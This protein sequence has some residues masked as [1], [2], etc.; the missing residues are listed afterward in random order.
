MP[1]PYSVV[2]LARP[3]AV[4]RDPGGSLSDRDVLGRYVVPLAMADRL[5]PTRV[6]QLARGHA[7]VRHA[8]AA[9][10]GHGV[11]RV[12]SGT[13]PVAY[14]LVVDLQMQARRT[15]CPRCGDP[16]S[17]LEGLREHAGAVEVVLFVCHQCAFRS[18]QP[19]FS[20][21]AVA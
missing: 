7:T 3:A 5:I 4:D 21:E 11:I 18:V 19:A 17:S 16:W 6:L 8:M 20:F 15:P 9:R 13:T 2:T 1:T 14:A 10:V 12:T